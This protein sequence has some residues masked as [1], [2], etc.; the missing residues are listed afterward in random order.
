MFVFTASLKTLKKKV[1]WRTAVFHAGIFEALQELPSVA[2]R[3]YYKCLRNQA[4]QLRNEYLNVLY[5]ES[6]SATLT[7]VSE[8]T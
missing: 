1:G 2:L 8:Y 4:Q 3:P 5:N 7:P 6:L